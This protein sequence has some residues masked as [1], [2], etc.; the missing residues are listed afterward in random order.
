MNNQTKFLLT[1]EGLED[2]KKEFNNLV[3]VKRTEAVKRVAAA[4]E[5]GDL[6]EN[7]EYTA[8]R[9]ELNMIDG[10]NASY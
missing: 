10:S 3:N 5:Q 1:K 9:E 4:R 7:S 2:L 6:S 8:S